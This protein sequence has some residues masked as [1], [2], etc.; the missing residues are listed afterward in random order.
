MARIG[1]IELEEN[2]RYGGAFKLNNPPNE[3]RTPGVTLGDTQGERSEI[4]LD[5]GWKATLSGETPYIV[6]QSDSEIDQDEIFEQSFAAATQALDVFS[7]LKDFEGEC[8]DSHNE[9]ILWW[10]DSGQ[11]HIQLTGIAGLTSSGSARATI[12]GE[13]SERTVS[14]WHES[15]RYY[16]LSKTTSDLFD[17]YRN[18][19]LAVEHLLSDICPKNSNERDTDWL[20]RALKKAHQQHDLSS[21]ASGQTNPIHS[22][23]DDHWR[24]VRCP[25][26]H[27][28]VGFDRLEPRNSA[29]VQLVRDRLE[30]LTKIY[31]HL[32]RGEFG[33][34]LGTGGMSHYAFENSMKE[35]LQNTEVAISADTSE[36]D[37]STELSEISPMSEFHPAEHDEGQSENTVQVSIS[38]IKASEVAQNL[39]RRFALVKRSN[40]NEDRII[41]YTN[42]LD[43]VDIAKFDILLIKQGV[44]HIT[45]S[46]SNIK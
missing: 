42:L 46:R 10:D 25:L 5:D 29:D 21:Y 31:S 27:S 43:E 26:F 14:E 23:L 2:Y 12:N 32:V 38:D 35:M 40:D 13:K 30:D 17:A 22:I 41:V 39:I 33:R 9:N 7:I 28:K 19:F 15:F 34:P 1:Q 8:V 20:K 3:A 16:R 4:E 6:V 37:R 24:D 36:W 44:R 45:G 18:Q 11:K